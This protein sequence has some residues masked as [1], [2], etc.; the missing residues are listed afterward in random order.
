MPVNEL[1]IHPYLEDINYQAFKAN[2]FENLIIGT[3]PVY[4]ITDTLTLEGEIQ[5]HAFNENDAYMRFFYGSKKNSFWRL[6]THGLGEQINPVDL[7]L[8][9]RKEA[10]IDLLTKHRFLITDVLHKTNREE[11]N[12]EDNYLWAGTNNDFVLNNRSLNYQI[13]QLLEDNQNI[14]YLYFTATVLNRK[15]PFGWFRAIF[16]NQ[17]EYNIIQQVADR[18]ISAEIQINK[19][20]YIAFFLPSPAS[21]GTRGLHFT[22]N[23]RTEIFVN[24]MESEDIDFYNEI[25]NLPKANRT[26]E[27]VRTLTN[28]RKTYLIQHYTEVLQN[29]NDHFNGV[30]N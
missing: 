12:A 28:L 15:S 4:G 14:N 11:E 25:N 29:K 5:A 1:E 13:E 7:P 2:H 22:D 23:S 19:R 24:Y 27:Q 9:E 10:A 26:Q 16:Q 20:K 8:E 17:L 18:P 3:F 30:V 6:V 21:N